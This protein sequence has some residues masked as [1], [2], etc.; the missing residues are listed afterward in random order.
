[1]TEAQTEAPRRRGWSPERRAAHEQGRAQRQ[2]QRSEQRTNQT[3]LGRTRTGRIRVNNSDMFWYDESL[4]PPHM[5]YQWNVVSVLGNDQ[6]VRRQSVAMKMNGWT[7]VPAS[8]HP[9]IMGSNPTEE[10]IIIGGQRLDERAIEM[11]DEAETE[12]YNA[13]V[14]QVKDNFRQLQ[15]EEA[16]Q[17]PRRNRDKGSLVSVKRERP[18]PVPDDASYDYEDGGV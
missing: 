14:A 3:K 18:I 15:H 2:E 13:A 17:L 7:P 5:A 8:R 10:H 16:G 1:M 4:R 12:D 9:E 6:L 11:S